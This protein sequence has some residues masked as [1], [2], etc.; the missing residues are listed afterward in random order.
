MGYYTDY[1]L[2]TDAEEVLSTEEYAIF[3]QAVYG[4]GNVHDLY[5]EDHCKWYH[6]SD[7]MT[8]LSQSFPTV[9]FA[10][11]GEGEEPGDL[12]IAYFFNGKKEV[13]GAS[14]W[15]PGSSNELLNKKASKKLGIKIA[16]RETKKSS[17]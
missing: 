1:S 2:V 7:D 10:L 5:L 6:W 13:H 15:F 3:E 4:D 12:W 16:S 14:I 17:D 8:A 11:R 9:T